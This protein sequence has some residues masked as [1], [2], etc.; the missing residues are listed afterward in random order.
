M[1]G[2]PGNFPN[3]QRLQALAGGNQYGG[4]PV[5]PFAG[6]T[7]MAPRL[8]TGVQAPPAM[9]FMGQQRA[10]MAFAPSVA[11]SAALNPALR[12]T[13][14]PNNL[15]Q[16]L[17]TPPGLITPGPSP[18]TINPAMFQRTPTPQLLAPPPITA[19]PSMGM[20]NPAFAGGPPVPQQ[21]PPPGPAA[22]NP[23]MFQRT[24][25]PM[26]LPTQGAGGAPVSG[27]PALSAFR[28]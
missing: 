19:P 22:M 25:V 20:M 3:V 10:P 9:N 18:A 28:R 16:K 5:N 13:F 8:A 27:P 26:M 4:Q 6:G 14:G 1:Q 17:A 24:A 21:V 2:F 12:Q 7:P 11:G 23:A 15:P